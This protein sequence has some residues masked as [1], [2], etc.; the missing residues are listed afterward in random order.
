MKTKGFTLIELLIVI[1]ILGILVSLILPRFADVREDANTKVCVANMRG[2]VSAMAIY[3]TRQNDDANWGVAPYIVAN[4]VNWGYVA[5]EP[6]CPY[7]NS[8]SSPDSYTLVASSGSLTD[9]VTCP[10]VGSYTNHVWP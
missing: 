9:R 1:A 6:R 8:E 10:N 2:L 5:A 4:L 3:E 7:E